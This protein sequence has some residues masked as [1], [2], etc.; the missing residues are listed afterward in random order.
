MNDNRLECTSEKKLKIKESLAKTRLKRSSQIVKCFECKIVE[1][2]LNGR[3][4]EELEMLFIEGKWF[5]NHVL[6]LHEN[7]ELGK[8]NTTH[9][10]QI[11]KFGKDKRKETK[12]LEYLSAA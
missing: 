11:E 10:K 8:I 3:Q 1:K 2:R 9:I 12:N 5:Y 7:T 4:R 6:N